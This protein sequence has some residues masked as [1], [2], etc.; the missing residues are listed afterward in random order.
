MQN[1]FRSI[2][3]MSA[4]AVG[5]FAQTTVTDDF[6]SSTNWSSATS[7][8]GG[9]L[10]ISGGQANYTASTPTAFD[11]SYLTWTGG[12]YSYTSNWEV[13]VDI[14]FA[15]ASSLTTNDK[16]VYAQLYV[17]PT[18]DVIN[19]N[20][21]LGGDVTFNAFL[22]EVQ[23][24]GNGDQYIDTSY[25]LN[26][27]NSFSESGHIS[28]SSTDIAL[29]I[30]FDSATKRLETY[31]DLDGATGGYS[32][33][34]NEFG[35]VDGS[36]NWNMSE[37]STFTLGLTNASSGSTTGPTI[38]QGAVSFDNFSVTSMSAVPE[39]STYAALAGLGALGLVIWQRR[40][41]L[42]AAR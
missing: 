42:A 20:Q 4:C 13:Q 12:V 35:D 10:A 16:N 5:A 29:R 8:G 21:A 22:V 33:T 7:N 25:V 15:P 18:G 28:N 27:D 39:P 23:R 31:Y 3:L 17:I 40:K 37:G 41:T 36:E 24:Y 30:T 34:F 32:W 2:M 6:S 19:W 38:E 9:Q 26:D 11:W 1:V 14:H